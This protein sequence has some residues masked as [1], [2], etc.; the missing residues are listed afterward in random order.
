VKTDGR[1]FINIPYFC[2]KYL[3]NSK[4][5]LKYCGI[6]PGVRDFMTVFSNEKIESFTIKNNIIHKLNQRIQEIKKKRSKKK[7]RKLKKLQAKKSNI[8]DEIHHKVINDLSKSFDV[9]FYGDINSHD[10]VKKNNINPRLNRDVNDLKFYKFKERLITKMNR[11]G[12]KVFL[13]NEAYT[14]KTCSCCG[15]IYNIGKSKIYNCP[16]RYNLLNPIKTSNTL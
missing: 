1:F 16:D 14:T 6:D 5:G 11:I 2:E 8:V 15:N 12:K 4:A 10:I 9:I 13:V 7:R 3:K